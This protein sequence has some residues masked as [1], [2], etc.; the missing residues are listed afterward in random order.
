MNTKIKNTLDGRAKGAATSAVFNPRTMFLLML[1]GVFSFSA[2]FVLSGFSDK[3]RNGNN[4]AEH[5][6]SKSAIGYAGL[7]HLLRDDENAVSVS[8]GPALRDNNRNRLRIV[9]LPRTKS[10]D[11][12]DDLQLNGPTLIVLPKWNTKAHP[13]HKGWVK[14]R[15]TPY[16]ALL[17]LTNISENLRAVTKKTTLKRSPS[18]SE[19]VTILAKEGLG[20]N[21]DINFYSF[22]R[23]QT[24]SG[25]DLTPILVSDNGTIMARVI[26]TEIYI[27]AD[28]DFLNTY[29]VAKPD[30]GEFAL[31]LLYLIASE[32]ESNG[33]V[34]DLS[35]HGFGRSQNFIK[36][37][38]TP[39]F[40]AVTLCLLAMA[41]LIA[42]QAFARFGSPLALERK[43]TLGK[44]SLIYN[45]S[46]F[47][48]RAGRE[49]RMAGEYTALTKKLAI[50][51]LHLPHG[52][53]EQELSDRLDAYSRHAGAETNW[54]ELE[55]SLQTPS[56]A[57]GLMENA[58]KLYKW[59]E[60]LT[61]G[62]TK[63]KYE[64]GD[65]N[66]RN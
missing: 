4:G 24:I 42:W 32:T 35:L 43:I 3:F 64:T 14:K 59:R 27:L 2:Y 15:N 31:D 47:I 66:G 57:T 26:D 23:L 46:D 11:A 54:S 58:R 5:V 53:N 39:P 21:T 8:R 65:E 63:N 36:L 12:I 60:A 22:A 33:F 48:K 29:S 17:K 13:S 52:L 56:N 34:F 37:A 45:A 7:M 55:N 18:K 50:E 51:Q 25:G 19:K 10:V 44:L 61:M 16:S 38:L 41:L 49:Y 62:Q 9:T 30:I 6:L 1:L 40:L 28:P 20:D